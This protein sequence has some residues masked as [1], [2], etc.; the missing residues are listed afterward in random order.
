MGECWG[1]SPLSAA[2]VR[3]DWGHTHTMNGQP[4]TLEKCRLK[5]WKTKQ[6][7]C[8]LHHGGTHT[9]RTWPLCLMKNI[10]PR[11]KYKSNS[12]TTS[13]TK[14]DHSRSAT[15]PNAMHC[16]RVQCGAWGTY[17]P[18]LGQTPTLAISI[19]QGAATSAISMAMVAKPP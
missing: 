16:T 12:P 15:T 4:L 3:R 13:H 8:A 11:Q 18:C 14:P 19:N 2:H 9:T 10:Q 6:H 1:W 17:A 5:P 7:A